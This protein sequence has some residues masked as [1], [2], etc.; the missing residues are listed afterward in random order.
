MG[1]ARHETRRDFLRGLARGL[2]AGGAIAGVGG[3]AA[4]RGEK[5]TNQFVCRGCPAF[6]GCGL[7]QALSAKQTMP[8]E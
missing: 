7:P 2:L 1:E 4:R 6:D 5:C 8:R 3:L